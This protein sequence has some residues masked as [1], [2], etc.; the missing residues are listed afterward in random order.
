MPSWYR[1]SHRRDPLPLSLSLSP[2]LPLAE[3]IEV[4]DPRADP[5]EDN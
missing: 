4:I 3:N 1:K 5:Y 2:P